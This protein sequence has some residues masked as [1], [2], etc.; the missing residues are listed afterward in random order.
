[1]CVEMKHLHFSLF[2]LEVTKYHTHTHTQRHK[3][4]R[5]TETTTQENLNLI[6]LK[7]SEPQMHT[8]IE[9]GVAKTQTLPMLSLSWKTEHM[10]CANVVCN[11]VRP[12]QALLFLCL[13]V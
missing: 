12:K 1:M 9:N 5:D 3:H 2:V 8:C 11:L 13:F 4:T 10:I 7:A 6:S